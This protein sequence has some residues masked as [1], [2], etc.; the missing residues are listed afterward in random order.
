MHKQTSG[1][2]A[3]GFQDSPPLADNLVQQL[4]YHLKKKGRTQH[5]GCKKSVPWWEAP[6]AETKIRE[7]QEFISTGIRP[8]LVQAASRQQQQHKAPASRLSCSFNLTEYRLKAKSRNPIT[9]A[10]SSFAQHVILVC[11]VGERRKTLPLELPAEI[12]HLIWWWS[13][14]VAVNDSTTKTWTAVVS[15]QRSV[16]SAISIVPSDGTRWL[17]Y[18]Q[19]CQARL[20]RP[21]REKT[22]P[23]QWQPEQA[24]AVNGRQVAALRSR[25]T[26]LTKANQELAR[27]AHLDKIA[28]ASTQEEARRAAS[29]AAKSQRRLQSKCQQSAEDMQRLV[30]IEHKRNVQQAGVVQRFNAAEKKRKADY[31]AFKRV[32]ADALRK[33]ERINLEDNSRM[34]MRRTINNQEETI[35]NQQEKLEEAK[36]KSKTLAAAARKAK[37]HKAREQKQRGKLK[38][39]IAAERTEK[40]EIADV[41]RLTSQR[42]RK[43]VSTAMKT[44]KEL[45]ATLDAETKRRITAETRVAA[46][47]KEL[48]CSQLEVDELLGRVEELCAELNSAKEITFLTKEGGRQYNDNLFAACRRLLRLKIS[49]KLIPD[50]LIQTAKAFGQTLDRV[51]SVD[52]VRKA[53]EELSALVVDRVASTLRQNAAST[54]HNS[55]T[56]IHVDAT[57]KGKGGKARSLMGVNI[58]EVSINRIFVVFTPVSTYFHCCPSLFFGW[59]W[60]CFFL[61]ALH[62]SERNTN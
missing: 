31:A 1:S 13:L 33:Q 28:L 11:L 52:T 27:Q 51:P 14:D 26:K 57:S 18:L 22:T 40:A 62:P 53:R 24:T 20:P 9:A 19:E 50:I 15:S 41:F 5:N 2:T 38:E 42:L 23:N 21:S 56:S 45:K 43:R 25:C 47:L 39:A 46:L 7:I 29:Q 35:K 10:A 36:K 4:K 60:Q 32:Q 55:F 3:F 30:S 16:S 48:E 58:H 59:T 37:T 34:K 61:R 8:W 6:F 49:P 12:W 44:N 17:Q 54:T